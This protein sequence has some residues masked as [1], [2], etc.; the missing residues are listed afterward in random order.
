LITFLCLRVC[1]ALA[2]CLRSGGARGPGRVPLV[3]FFNR[4]L[5]SRLPTPGECRGPSILPRG[6]GRYA[7]R[8]AGSLLDV[9]A[10]DRC[11]PSSSGPRCINWRS[12]RQFHSPLAIGQLPSSRL[13]ALT[14]SWLVR[15]DSLIVLDLGLFV[16]EPTVHGEAKILGQHGRPPRA[17]EALS[18]SSGQGESS[19]VHLHGYVPLVLVL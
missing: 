1:F 12:G 14:L 10:M 19:G 5:A 13:L 7:A 16:P 15:G 18:S 6:S 8:P 3:R 4:A 2:H 11:P 17:S 9:I